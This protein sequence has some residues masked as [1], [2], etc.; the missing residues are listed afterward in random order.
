MT[1]SR[2]FSRKTYRADSVI[3]IA[4]SSAK[5]RP[6]MIA[7]FG[8]RTFWGSFMADIFLGVYRDNTALGQRV[9]RPQ[10]DSASCA[11][12]CALRFLIASSMA[13]RRLDSSIPS[14]LAAV[15]LS[16]RCIDEF[17]RRFAPEIIVKYDLLA[18]VIGGA[19]SKAPK[20]LRNLIND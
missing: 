12:F 16:R 8:A 11:C 1:G 17:S 20:T 4:I 13:S 2:A 10:I 7:R 3:A 9:W 6:T 15:R 14:S 5:P 18:R 19:V